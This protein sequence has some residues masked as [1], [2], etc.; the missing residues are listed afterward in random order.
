MII[1]TNTKLITLDNQNGLELTL[2]SIGASIFDIKVIDKD[3]KKES[4]VIRPKNLEDFVNHKD[5]F[6]KT[7]GRF[8]GRI[9]KGKCFIDENEYNIPI[10]WNNVNALHGGQEEAISHKNWN[11]SIKE[12]T[13]F[14]DVIFTYFEVEHYLP[15]NID[16]KVTY[17]V[18]NDINKFDILLEA[19]SNKKTLINL[20]N[21]AYFNLSGDGKNNIL[22]HKLKL[23]CPL[24]TNLNNE[25]IAT[26]ID[27]V[28]KIMDFTNEKEIGLHINDESLQ[29]HTAF[30]YDHC[31]IK[32]DTSN[33]VIAILK[34]E[35]SKRR[36]TVSTSLPSVVCYSTNY[37]DDTMD[38]NVKNNK[39]NK[40]HAITLECQYVPNGIN[41]ENVNK[42]IFKENEKYS[43]YISYN[44]D[45][46]L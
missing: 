18:Y 24:Y 33:D 22:S 1:T 15:G 29:N 35:V 26:S 44:F 8:S 4:I 23:N 5:Y 10:N 9:D 38:F 46:M 19:I 2:C 32:T 3:N 39:L 16:Y 20:T 30:G 28:N 11:Y 36:L 42:A 31:F 14:V 41:M 7:I 45:I 43:H 37:P 27:N 13:D 40:Y 12:N 21:H 6:G 17:R 25:L 34:D